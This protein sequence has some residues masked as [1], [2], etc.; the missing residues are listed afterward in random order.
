MAFGDLG[1]AKQ[2]AENAPKYKRIVEPFGDVG[3]IAL[4]PGK[5][6]PKSHQVNIQDET[7]FAVMSFIK[8]HTA[9]DKKRLKGFDWTAAPETF[10]AALAITATEGAE[11][12]Y[13]FFYVK[14]FGVRAK[15]PEQ[16]P[17]YDHLKTGHDMKAILYSLPVQRVG[18]K[19]V[20]LTND[21]PL[22]VLGTIS[23]SDTFAILVPK[24]PEH[25]EAV[26]NRLP[27]S[28]P[29]FYAKKSMSNDDLFEAVARTG[30]QVKVSQF[31][32]SSIMMASMEVHT[33]YDN[34]LTALEPIEGG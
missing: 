20:E 23:G 19:K 14:K 15:D 3:T 1:I 34:K 27:L 18:L 33:N 29:F 13:R 32:V 24:K 11:L 22:A 28:S 16:P 2:I 30:D 31:A 5:K 17:T 12:Y 10:E 8:S 4:Y 26:E 9:G 7:A 6:K 21:D 25:I